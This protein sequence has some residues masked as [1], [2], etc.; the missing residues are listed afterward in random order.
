MKEIRNV[1]DRY[2]ARD[3]NHLG[4]FIK[5]KNQPAGYEDF[6]G[7][8]F[9]VIRITDDGTLVDLGDEYEEGRRNFTLDEFDFVPPSEII[10]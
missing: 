6:N 1:D 5:V 2:D 10:I 7:K 8:I 4:L 9:K 3:V